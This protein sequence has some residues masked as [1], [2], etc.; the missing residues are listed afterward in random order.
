MKDISLCHFIT[1]W[2]PQLPHTPVYPTATLPPPLVSLSERSTA[3]V[4]CV[5]ILMYVCMYVYM[6]E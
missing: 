6:Y 3:G 5:H 1:I 2:L 4:Y